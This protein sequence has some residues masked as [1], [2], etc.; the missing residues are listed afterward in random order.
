MD[1]QLDNVRAWLERHPRIDRALERTGCLRFDRR[2]VSRGVGVGLFVAL[3]PTV[4]VQTG[5]M[6]GGCLLVRGNFPVAFVISW[7]SNPVTMAP[8]Y[9]GYHALGEVLFGPIL[10]AG[11]RL[12]G[13]G[14]NLALEVVYVALGSLIVAAPVAA[15]G[16]LLLLWG[17]GNWIIRRRNAGFSA[18]TAERREAARSSRPER[19]SDDDGE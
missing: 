2:S 14:E 10:R 7:I 17:W 16:Y 11:M 13:Y 12:L 3:T 4:G 15:A 5:M 8:L 9:M 6:L 1:Y 19:P 18:R